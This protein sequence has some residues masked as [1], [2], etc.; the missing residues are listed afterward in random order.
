MGRKGSL[1]A[2]VMSM[3]NFFQHRFRDLHNVITAVDDSMLF[4]VTEAITKTAN[5]GGKVVLVGNGG[6]AAIAS[7][8]AVDLTKAA[9]V[10]ASNFNESSLLTCF[11]NDFGYENWVSEA[12]GF[13]CDPE[14]LVILISSSGVSRNMVNAAQR[15]REMGLVCI[16][17]SGFA[18][19][20]PLCTQGRINLWVDS[21]DYNLIENAHQVWLL[22]VVDLLVSMRRDNS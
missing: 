18:S 12:L 13:Y 5:A 14:D 21:Q 16:T 11:S 1:E 10:R 15:A 4:E 8:V 6:S 19:D 20:N 9:G 7:H 22:S 17:L 2:V 3:K